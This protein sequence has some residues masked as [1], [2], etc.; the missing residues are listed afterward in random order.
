VAEEIREPRDLRLLLVTD[1]D[2]LIASCP[3]LAL[4]TAEDSKDDV[5]EL[6][7][8]DEEKSALH[9]AIGD[10]DESTTFRDEACSFR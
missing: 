7:A 5:V 2:G 1:D 4:C 9:C 3:N 10:L 6:R 8:R